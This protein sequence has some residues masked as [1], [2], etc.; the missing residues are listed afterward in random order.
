MICGLGWDR[1]IIFISKSGDLP[2]LFVPPFPIK[3]ISIYLQVVSL[4]DALFLI[5]A[6]KTITSKVNLSY[7][8]QA[9]SVLQSFLSAQSTLPSPSSSIPLSQFSGVLPPPPPSSPLL[10]EQG[11]PFVLSAPSQSWSMPSPFMSQASG[12]ISGSLSLQSST[13]P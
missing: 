6:W 8:E 3:K 13:I 2:P 10:P 1:G 11:L 12:L 5:I 4:V 9:G 7:F